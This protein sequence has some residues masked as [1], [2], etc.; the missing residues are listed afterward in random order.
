MDHPGAGLVQ[1]LV[2]KAQRKLLDGIGQRAGTPMV[3]L[4]AAWAD[5]VLYGGQ[6]QRVGSDLDVL[7]RPAAFL[8]C[9]RGLEAEGFRRYVQPWMRATF[10]WGYKAWTYEGQPRW[11]TVDLHRGIAEPP[12]FALP[13]DDCID[14]AV[15]Y[16][17]VDGPILSLG[18]EDQV[19]YAA[20][21]YGNHRFGIDQRH[22]DDI[23]RLVKVRAIDWPVVIDRARALG[24]AVP[25]A[26]VQESLRARG[27]SAPPPAGGLLLGWRL[28]YAHRWVSS[29]PRLERCLPPSRVVDN[30]LRMP[31]LSGRAAAL[32]RFAAGYLSLRA[33]DLA[34]EVLH[35][36]AP[37][38]AREG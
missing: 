34:A 28:A 37:G 38:S 20:A 24:L 30:A 13:A 15:A 27:A 29:G 11:M 19:L 33:L 5:P 26:L 3:Y 36:F 32:P 22:L 35:R 18:P 21:H 10:R 16:D 7:V 8:A 9:A 2:I 4:K 31:L 12:W 1:S 25:L 6:G 17:S 23:E 14:R